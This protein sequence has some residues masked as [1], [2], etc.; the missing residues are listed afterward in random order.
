VLQSEAATNGLV[1]VFLA[2]RSPERRVC[3]MPGDGG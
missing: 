3:T 2:P 1:T